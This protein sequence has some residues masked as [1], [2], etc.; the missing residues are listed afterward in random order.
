MSEE[1]V[2]KARES[3][4]A[5]NRGDFDLALSYCGDEVVFDVGPMFS[6]VGM[7]VVLRGHEAVKQFW[8][9]LEEHL[10]DLRLELSDFR[11]AGDFV[12]ATTRI[13]GRG[14]GS[15]VEVADVRHSVTEFRDGRIARF[16]LF[17]TRDEALEAAG[18]SE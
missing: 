5:Y 12:Y 10:E 1:N 16:K 15:E 6:A 11:D 9:D 18:L 13:V 14:R 17:P 2:D 4:D 7:A 8:Q 3:I